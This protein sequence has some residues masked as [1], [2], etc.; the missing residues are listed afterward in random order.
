MG[1]SLDEFF[2]SRAWEAPASL[3]GW[4]VTREDE[5]V[6]LSLS[7]KDGERYRVRFICDGYPEKAPSVMFV[8][9]QGDKVDR[10]AW[11]AGDN[12]FYEVV[13]PPQDCFLCMPWTRE[14]L[15]H[16]RDWAGK[17]STDPW[18]SQKSLLD[19]FNYLQRLLN[20]NQYSHR[21]H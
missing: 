13:K 16:H 12:K 18:T 7:A 1:K 8:N 4:E 15:E 2:T 19:L 20:S 6:Y 14:G 17:P 9:Q 10:R 11:P 21:G 3:L 5:L